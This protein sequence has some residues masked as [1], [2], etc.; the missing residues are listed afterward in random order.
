MCAVSMIHDQFHQYPKEW[1][2]ND[3]LDLF[4]ELVKKMEEYDK[5]IGQPDCVDPVKEQHIREVEEYL[6][7]L[8][9]SR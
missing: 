3:K 2:D 5:R 1:W 6:R 4:K 7:K 9:A 8:K